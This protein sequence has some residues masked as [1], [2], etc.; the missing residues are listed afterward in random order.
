MDNIYTNE[1]VWDRESGGG[2]GGGGGYIVLTL[3]NY[4]IFICIHGVLT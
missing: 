1:N 4:C 3:V 2:G